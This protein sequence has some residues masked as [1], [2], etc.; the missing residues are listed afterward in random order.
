V[1]VDLDSGKKVALPGGAGQPSRVEGRQGSWNGLEMAIR[2][3]SISRSISRPD[4]CRRR[5]R[6]SDGV[7]IAARVA[8]FAHLMEGEP[9]PFASLT[10]GA[11]AIVV[12][13]AVARDRRRGGGPSS[14]QRTITDPEGLVAL[15]AAQDA[16]LQPFM[17][18]CDQAARRDLAGS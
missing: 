13:A 15:G 1:A 8:R 6:H 9:P 5:S 14:R 4:R 7:R 16:T 11:G 17:A 2:S 12:E 18:A 3:R 10:T